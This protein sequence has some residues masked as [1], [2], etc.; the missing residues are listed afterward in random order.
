MLLQNK[1]NINDWSAIL[2]LFD[3]LNTQLAKTQADQ[4]IVQTG[5]LP[6]IY[7]RTLAELEDYIKKTFDDKEAKKKMS[8]TN[9]KAFNTMRQRLK[10]HNVQYTI[11]LAKYRENPASTEEEEE[12]EEPA[13]S[14]ESEDEEGGLLSFPDS[15]SCVHMLRRTQDRAVATV[16]VGE[17]LGWVGCYPSM[18]FTSSLVGAKMA[19][20]LYKG[21][22]LSDGALP[23]LL[24]GRLG[25]RRAVTQLLLNWLGV[26][27]LLC[28]KGKE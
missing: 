7:L 6:R 24:S 21:Q 4:T 5:K 12:E 22:G 26:G 20:T 23:K 28:G 14:S 10:K 13:S 11:E 9:A 25:P 15:S 3:K 27:S 2:P 17:L 16:V 1:L 18:A 8:P 19:P